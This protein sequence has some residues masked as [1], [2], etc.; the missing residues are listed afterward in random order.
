MHFFEEQPG[1][2]EDTAVYEWQ[3]EGTAGMKLAL[4]NAKASLVQA[5]SL[6]QP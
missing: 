4:P 3:P 6:C 2:R 1:H 5:E